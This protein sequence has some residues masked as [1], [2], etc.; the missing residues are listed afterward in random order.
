MFTEIHKSSLVELS[1]VGNLEKVLREETLRGDKV[2][3]SGSDE[4][5]PLGGMETVNLRGCVPSLE[6]KFGTGRRAQCRE[7]SKQKDQGSS[8][9][10]LTAPGTQKHGVCGSHFEL[11]TSQDGSRPISGHSCVGIHHPCTPPLLIHPLNAE[12]QNVPIPPICYL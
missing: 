12:D 7:P 3:L 6:N 4:L 10:N 9:A 1:G 5:G 2:F 11:T 8:T